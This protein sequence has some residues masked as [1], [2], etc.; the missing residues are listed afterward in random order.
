MGSLSCSLHQL[1]NFTKSELYLL[2]DFCLHDA[3]RL[4][5]ESGTPHSIL[6]RGNYWEAHWVCGFVGG[7]VSNQALTIPVSEVVFLL[8]KFLPGFF[9]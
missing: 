5:L 6:A 8:L 7:A 9:D 3:R 4:L 2:G 1:A